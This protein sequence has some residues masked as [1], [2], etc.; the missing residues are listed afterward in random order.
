MRCAGCESISSWRSSRRGLPLSTRA[1]CGTV[2]ATCAI[3][4]FSSADPGDTLFA[5]GCGRL[6]EGNPG[7]MWASL[8]K[9]LP[10]PRSATVFCAHEYT[11]VASYSPPL[12]IT[13][14]CSHMAEGHMACLGV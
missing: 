3:G 12:K 2:R 14:G 6:F 8:S 1:S 11:Q 4:Q 7:Q 5:L 13:A 10:L 9:M